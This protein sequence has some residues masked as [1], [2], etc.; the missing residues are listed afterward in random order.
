MLQK[1][2][3]AVAAASALLAISAGPAAAGTADFVGT[4]QNT[5]TRTDNITRVEVSR[6]GRGGGLRVQVF[7]QCSPRDCDWGTVSA[8]A[9]APS[10]GGNLERDANVL[11]A[12]FP[13]SFSRQ[14]VILRLQRD[15]GVRYETFTD[16]TDRSGRTSYATQGSLRR[17]GIVPPRP[18]PGRPGRDDHDD[19]SSL[20]PQDCVGFTNGSLRVVAGGGPAGMWRIMDG[21]HSIAAF[22]TQAAA[23]QALAVIRGYGFQSQCFIERPNAAMTYWLRGDDVPHRALRTPEDCI[24]VNTDAVT[25]RNVRGSWKVVDGSTWLLD[26]GVNREAADNA[27]AVIRHY[28][29][30]RQC[31]VAR[32]GNSMQYWLSL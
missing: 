11:I 8:S 10:A 17:L 2:A 21:S 5:D 22:R 24:V 1:L 23:N 14:T 30:N 13:T 15:G 20:P 18:G 7:G 6:A 26:F 25:V 31:F 12:N 3:V 29:L 27:L 16:F 28:N 32:P 9:Y 19:Y 4:W